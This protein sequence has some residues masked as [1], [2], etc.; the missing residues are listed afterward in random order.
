MADEAVKTE[1]VQDGVK[2][3]TLLESVAWHL[4]SRRARLLLGNLIVLLLV[5]WDALGLSQAEALAY[6]AY[7][8]AAFCTLIAALTGDKVGF[9][10]LAEA[11][12]AAMQ[13]SD[14]EK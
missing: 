1:V 12:F 13:K 11:L 3:F 9:L 6:G 2:K 7:A 10:K 5:Q 14:E 4:K 8:T